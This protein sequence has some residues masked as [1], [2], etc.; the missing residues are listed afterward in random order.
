MRLPATRPA[1]GEG[2]M[3]GQRIAGV[4]TYVD[5]LPDGRV[6]GAT[7][8]HGHRPDGPLGVAQRHAVP[9]GQAQQGHAGR[10]GQGQ[11][12]ARTVE[13]ES[14]GHDHRALFDGDAQARDEAPAVQ[15]AVAQARLVALVVLLAL[16]V[17]CGQQLAGEEAGTLELSELGHAGPLLMPGG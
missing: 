15:E 7:V 3:P 13:R 4:Q 5:R 10:L 14:R 17:G 8:R 9:T 1:R 16:E 2:A 11:F 6:F 12:I